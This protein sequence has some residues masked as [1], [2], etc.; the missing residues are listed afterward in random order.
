MLELIS[1]EKWNQPKREKLIYHLFILKTSVML[2]SSLNGPFVSYE[3][4]TVLWVWP[5]TL[6]SYDW[7]SLKTEQTYPKWFFIIFVIS[8]SDMLERISSEK[9]NQPKREKLIYH[10]FI[11]KKKR[12]LLQRNIIK[13]SFLQSTKIP[14]FLFPSKETERSWRKSLS[15]YIRARVPWLYKVNF[16]SLWSPF[17]QFTPAWKWF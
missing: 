13:L 15:R 7:L 8:R 12:F 5:L 9:W 16:K 10:V 11:L 3:E 14:S 1:A 2:H 4:I 6:K 17:R